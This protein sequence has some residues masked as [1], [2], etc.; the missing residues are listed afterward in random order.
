MSDHRRYDHLERVGHPEVEG[1]DVGTVYVFPKLDGANASIWLSEGELCC[2]SRNLVLTEENGLMGF[3]EWVASNADALYEFLRSYPSGTRIY[4]EWMVPHT[5]KTYRD[6]VWRRFWVFDLWNPERQRYH[7]FEEYS[8]ITD[9]VGLDVVEPL[10]IV[11]N[12]TEETLLK[13]LNSNTYLIQDGQGL[14]EGIVLK[15]YEWINSNGRQPWAKIV[16]TEFKE[17]NRRAF[18]VPERDGG[19]QVEAAIAEEFANLTFV[20]KTRVKIENEILDKTGWKPW[21]AT[22]AGIRL[23]VLARHR[24][25]II[26]RLL[27][28]VYSDLI[29]EESWH[30]VKKYKNPTIDFKRL[31]QFVTAQVKRHAADLF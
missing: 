15:N 14:G 5:L 8:D 9:F 2:G 23:S 17:E 24:K 21:S 6:D 16:R 13:I 4:G 18:G 27:Q 22:E 26:P 10:S 3:R 19:F 25:E 12:P 7:H 31:Q 1:L 29:A 28:T 11:K 30:F 20:N